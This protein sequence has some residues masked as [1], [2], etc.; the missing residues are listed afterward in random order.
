[1][2]YANER[3]KDRVR[4]RRAISPEKLERLWASV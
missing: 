2:T 3:G 4:V 1:M